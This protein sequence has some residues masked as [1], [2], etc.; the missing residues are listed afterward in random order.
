MT[1][2]STQTASKVSHTEYINYC[3]NSE[4]AITL[5]CQ[6]CST[7]YHPVW[8]EK[9]LKSSCVIKV[10]S[11]KNTEFFSVTKRKPSHVTLHQINTFCCQ[12]I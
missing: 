7:C 1:G 11:M 3:L 9:Y 6:L 10:A 2:E 8:I 12:Q 5:R 4:I